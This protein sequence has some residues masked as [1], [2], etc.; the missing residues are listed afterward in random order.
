MQS[1][2]NRKRLSTSSLRSWKRAVIAALMAIVVAMPVLP[3]SPAEAQEI[4]FGCLPGEDPCVTVAGKSA[5]HITLQ[6]TGRHGIDEYHIRWSENGRPEQTVT[7]R[8]NWFAF[9]RLRP[10]TWYRF[11]VQRCEKVT[12]GK[13]RCGPWTGMAVRTSSPTRE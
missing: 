4:D 3:P 11:A 2:G 1:V 5:T 6:F 12:F 13:D 9:G 7:T 10:E 8:N